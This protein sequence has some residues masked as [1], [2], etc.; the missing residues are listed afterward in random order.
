MFYALSQRSRYT[1]AAI[2]FR[3]FIIFTYLKLP[4]TWIANCH[5]VPDLPRRKPTDKPERLFAF[6]VEKTKTAN[7]Y[8]TRTLRFIQKIMQNNWTSKHNQNKLPPRRRTIR[9]IEI[10]S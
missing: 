9:R 2:I 8:K 7:V 10:Q 1:V 3:K 5:S 6:Q 4:T